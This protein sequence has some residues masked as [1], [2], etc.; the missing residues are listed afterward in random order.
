MRELWYFLLLS[1]FVQ[2]TSGQ[3]PGDEDDVCL[4]LPTRPSFANQIVLMSS[5]NYIR[6]IEGENHPWIVVDRDSNN[7]GTS[8]TTV[9]DDEMFGSLSACNFCPQ[10][11]SQSGSTCAR[12]TTVCGFEEGP[13]DNWMIT[14]FINNTMR[15]SELYIK[16]VFSINSDDCNMG[17]GCQTTLDMRV[18]QTNV[19]NQSFAGDVSELESAQAFV[20]T[21]SIRDGSGL[22]QYVQ[23]ISANSDTTGFYMALRDRGTCVGVSEVT[24][25]YAVCDN[26]S[27]DF[28]ANFA[29]TRFPDE[30]SSGTC[31]DN[32]VINVDA[33]NDSFDA[34]CMLEIIRDDSSMPT[35]V[36]TNWTVSGDP[37]RRC[38]CLPGYEFTDSTT[39][40]QC[41]GVYMCVYVCVYVCVRIYV[42]TYVCA[43]TL[44]IRTV[45]LISLNIKK[46]SHLSS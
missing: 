10:S 38:M 39:T 32:M 36:I 23:T 45:A 12:I 24:V 43:C 7:G 13:Q 6:L 25:F 42:R 26:V 21:S 5:R 35:I 34:T 15:R 19:F 46:F 30:T 4:R 20:L 14:Q 44:C 11:W 37:S 9:R 33:P 17:L 8:S 41:R 40:S 27:L 3:A 22:I 16:V 18:L 1:I 31:F 29:E 28:G 2:A